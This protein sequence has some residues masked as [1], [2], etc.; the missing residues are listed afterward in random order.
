MKDLVDKSMGIVIL[1]AEAL[2]KIKHTERL[3]YA[4]R[5]TRKKR[6]FSL[7]I[8]QV[9]LR[10]KYYLHG[11]IMPYLYSDRI[12]QITVRLRSSRTLRLCVSV[13]FVR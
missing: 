2:A 1:I 12:V 8:H 4:K 9:I 5:A 6:N 13:P 10:P 7:R 3:R 11:V